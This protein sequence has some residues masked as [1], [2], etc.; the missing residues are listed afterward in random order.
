MDCKAEFIIPEGAAFTRT[1]V[2]ASMNEILLQKT[3]SQ[4]LWL[5]NRLT[6]SYGALEAMGIYMDFRVIKQAECLFAALSGKYPELKASIKGEY[7][8][9]P[10][11]FRF[12]WNEDLGGY[13]H[14]EL[15][16]GTISTEVTP[17]E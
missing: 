2:L 9:Y 15:E 6:I 16:N 13:F 12:P 11:R 5:S 17:I 7:S 1:Q 4:L 3:L 10:I 14:V 8:G